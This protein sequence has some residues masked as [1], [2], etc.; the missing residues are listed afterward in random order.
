MT[1]GPQRKQK[2]EI[3]SEAITDFIQ[4]NSYLSSYKK[5]RPAA[6]RAIE[7]EKAESEVKTP[8]TSAATDEDNVDPTVFALSGLGGKEFD[9][10]S[11]D[12]LEDTQATI[13][14]A[15]IDNVLQDAGVESGAKNADVE[16]LSASQSEFLGRLSRINTC[17]SKAALGPITAPH[18]FGGS[19][20]AP[21]YFLLE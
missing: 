3:S 2:R 16:K 9:D 7:R 19:R 4:Q 1:E 15:S 20:D 13:E 12:A 18:L 6:G 14:Q 21:A 8:S 10:L 17:A 5:P 11:H